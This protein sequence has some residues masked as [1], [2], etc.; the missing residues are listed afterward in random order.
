MTN[1]IIKLE[2]YSLSGGNMIDYCPKDSS[3]LD[4]KQLTKFNNIDDAL[5]PNGILILLYLTVSENYGHWCCVFKRDKDT[6]EFFDSYGKT[7]DEPL[8]YATDEVRL[9]TNSVCPHLAILLYKSGYK[10]EYNDH[11]LQKNKKSHLV[12]TCG[13]HV[14]CRLAARHLNIDNYV[15]YMF[16]NTDKDPDYIVTYLTKFIKK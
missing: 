9:K 6:I 12:S 4:Y 15:K 1:N 13:R 5:G 3:V 11:I 8:K 7:I 16:E 2:G 14:L 10:V